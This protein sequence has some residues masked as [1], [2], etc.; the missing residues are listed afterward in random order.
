MT[1]SEVVSK[2]RRAK[3][4]VQTRGSTVIGK[5]GKTYLRIKTGNWYPVRTF[6]MSDGIF[7]N[8]LKMTQ[9]AKKEMS[10]DIRRA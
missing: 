4:I 7:R 5:D 1:T 3:K 9:C 10:S 6:W 8:I 2:K